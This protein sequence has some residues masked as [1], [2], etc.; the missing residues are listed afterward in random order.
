M[1][2]QQATEMREH[3]PWRKQRY[4]SVGLKSDEVPPGWNVPSALSPAVSGSV[5]H[6]PRDWVGG[7]RPHP[8]EKGPAQP[9][10]SPAACL[11]GSLPVCFL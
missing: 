11:P 4:G 3:R 7:F 8:G 5:M 6:Q 9:W 1:V 2:E 10:E